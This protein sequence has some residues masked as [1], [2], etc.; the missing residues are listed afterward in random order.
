MADI[1]VLAVV[2]GGKVDTANICPSCAALMVVL[3]VTGMHPDG[4]V[5]LPAIH[6]CPDCYDPKQVVAEWREQVRRG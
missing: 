1:E 4:I 3:T 6:C 2:T 5:N